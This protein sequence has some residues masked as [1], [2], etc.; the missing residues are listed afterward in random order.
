MG[1][2]TGAVKAEAKPTAAASNNNAVSAVPAKKPWW[3]F[4]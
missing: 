4:W 3:K 2:A 1:Q